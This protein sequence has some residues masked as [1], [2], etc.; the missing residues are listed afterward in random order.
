MNYY[1]TLKRIAGPFAVTELADSQ[2]SDG[3]IRH[4][5][6]AENFELSLPVE[7]VNE[8]T[9][10]SGYGS[11][12]SRSSNDSKIIGDIGEEVV[13]KCE[14]DRLLNSGCPELANR[15]EWVAKKG[16]KPGYD[17]R[18][19][20]EDGSDRFIEVKS[21]KAKHHESI[22]ITENEWRTA[23]KSELGTYFLYFVTNVLKKPSI[24]I[25]ENPGHSGNVIYGVNLITATYRLKVR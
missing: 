11:K 3:D 22:T 10:K 12:K 2:I 9:G 1:S 16:E 25:W 23:R 24:Q 21:T 19:F 7:T 8:N 20:N 17:I 18:S 4:P 14:K 15:V 13:F 6:F 5:E